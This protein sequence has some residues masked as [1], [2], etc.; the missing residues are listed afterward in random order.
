M[1]TPKNIKSYLQF[2]TQRTSMNMPSETM[3]KWASLDAEKLQSVLQNFYNKSTWTKAEIQQYEFDFFSI[4][5]SAAMPPIIPPIASEIKTNQERFNAL[6]DL[7][8]DIEDSEFEVISSENLEIKSPFFKEPP[9]YNPTSI[10]TPILSPSSTS[11][12]TAIPIEPAPTLA[13]KP[14][15]TPPFAP[16]NFV[17]P[18]RKS[19]SIRLLLF[20]ALVAL[21]GLLLAYQYFNYKNLGTIYALTNNI[22]IRQADMESA[23][24]NGRLDLFGTH[25]DDANKPKTSYSE[26]KVVENDIN[27]QYIKVQLSESFS[28]YL[29]GNDAPAYVHRNIV[30]FSKSEHSK[31]QNVF[32]TL[33]NDF[34]EM[35]KLQFVYRKM[36]VN[37]LES[38]P[39]LR[40][41]TVAETCNIETKLSKKAPLSIGQ[42][43]KKDANNNVVAR[44]AIVQLSN[45]FYYTIQADK[46]GSVQKITQTMLQ[47]G[48]DTT[49]L[50]YKGKFK[51]YDPYNFTYGDFVWKSCDGA[52]SAKS[53]MEP[54][55]L[56]V[57]D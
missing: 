41:L 39:D 42:Y 24:L 9:V 32:R 55:D 19:R 14:S 22:S 18:K 17:T 46:E 48:S 1:I 54:F 45:G 40:G 56:F 7:D 34:N 49:P 12:S 21:V 23:D 8:D 3:D 50:L 16:S 35:D 33:A 51:Y 37:A 25:L 38:N 31:Y 44:F 10:P 5:A 2:L 4:L 30:S 28:S 20:L 47:Q 15:I 52:S 43:I 26:L 6:V 53:V 13:P 57:G 27:S 36:I 29:F 11:S